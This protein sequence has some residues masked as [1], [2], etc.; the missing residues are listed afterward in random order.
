MSNERKHV[1]LCSYSMR[2]FNASCVLPPRLPE[3]TNTSS[4]LHSTLYI[5]RC[6]LHMPHELCLSSELT[7][8]ILETKQLVCSF[9]QMLPFCTK[10]YSLTFTEI[11][12]RVNSVVTP[13]V[14]NRINEKKRCGPPFL[15]DQLKQSNQLVAWPLNILHSTW[16]GK[17]A[18]F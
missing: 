10:A 5:L 3:S 17:I 15:S 16:P 14:A 8:A 9:A 11:T 18:I 13:K 1:V 2:I 4:T 12:V 7:R 6:I